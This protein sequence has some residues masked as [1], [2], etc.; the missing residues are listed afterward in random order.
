MEAGKVLGIAILDHIIVTRDSRRWHSM[1]SSGT[2]PA[3]G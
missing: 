1:L 3:E 2:L